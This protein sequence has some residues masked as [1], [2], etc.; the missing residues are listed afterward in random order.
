MSVG[1]GSRCNSAVSKK[2]TFIFHFGE[3]A[4]EVV[5]WKCVVRKM[6]ILF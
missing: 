3:T 1:L 4:K 6:D 5:R 2:V